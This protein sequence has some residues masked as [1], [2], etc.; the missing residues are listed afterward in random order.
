MANVPC[1]TLKAMRNMRWLHARLKLGLPF[2]EKKERLK[3]FMNKYS[4]R[5]Q[6]EPASRLKYLWLVLGTICS[7]FSF[8]GRWDIALA[9]WLAPF[10]L[11]PFMLPSRTPIGL[12]RASLPTP[13]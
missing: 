7:L 2:W 13:L 1:V 6:M 12:T 3:D 11:L 10:F 5:R 4:F 9:A 8:N